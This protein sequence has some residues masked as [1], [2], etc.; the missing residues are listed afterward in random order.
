[1]RSGRRALLVCVVTGMHTTET[2]R[3]VGAGV[4]NSD[5]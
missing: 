2:G 3:R 4:L 1:M 5:Y